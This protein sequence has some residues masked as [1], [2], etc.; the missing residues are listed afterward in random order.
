MKMNNNTPVPPPVPLPS[1]PLEP[2]YPG[3]QDPNMPFP[4]PGQ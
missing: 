3:V 4:F 1:A 2:A